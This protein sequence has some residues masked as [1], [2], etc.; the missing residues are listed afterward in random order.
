MNTIIE[1]IRAEVERRKKKAEHYIEVCK[2]DSRAFEYWSG[3]RD[4]LELFEKEFLSTLQEKSEKPV[5]ADLE[6]AAVEYSAIGYSPFDDPYEKHQQF[7]CSKFAFIAGAKWQKEQ[8]RRNKQTY[9][10]SWLLMRL[11]GRRSER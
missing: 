4:V 10:P 11:K 3:E 1:K 6:E 5:S 7:E 8:M 9:S 2:A